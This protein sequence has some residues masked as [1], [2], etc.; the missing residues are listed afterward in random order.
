MFLHDFPFGIVGVPR[1]ADFVYFVAGR[2]L[3][4]PWKVYCFGPSNRRG[5]GQRFKRVFTGYQGPLGQYLM[6]HFRRHIKLLKFNGSEAFGRMASFF[7]VVIFQ[8]F[9]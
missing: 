9:L 2:S 6:D 8:E 3:G 4:N 1:V 7:A 5:P